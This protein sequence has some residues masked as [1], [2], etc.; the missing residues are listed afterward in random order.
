[1]VSLIGNAVELIDSENLPTKPLLV[2]LLEYSPENVERTT[3]LR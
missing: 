2:P 1:M 3:E